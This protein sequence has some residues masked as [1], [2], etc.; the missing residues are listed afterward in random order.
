MCEEYELVFSR[1]NKNSELYALNSSGRMEVSDDLLAVLKDAI[2]YCELSGGNFDITMG[3]LS[4]IYG[5]SSD[6]PQVPT[7]D[8]LDEILPHIDYRSIKIE[9]NLVTLTDPAVEIDL[10][11]IAKG[12]IADRMRDY[13]IDRGVQSALINL[14]GNIYCLGTKPNGNDFKISIQYPFKDRTETIADV[15]VRDMSVVTSGIYERY[16]E[17]GGKLYHH[18]L[19]PKTG[20]SYETNLL[21]TTI[22]GPDSEVCDALSTVTFTLGLDKGMELINSL[23][24]YEATFITEDNVLHNSEGFEKVR[25]LK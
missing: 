25:K 16:F 3:K 2:H 14:G 4:D 19:D 5:F 1:T 10:G 13:L 18:I 24:G 15:Y 8:Q 17:D 7:K 11:A 9:G 20:Y 6:N 21:S 23:E 12:Y 22:I